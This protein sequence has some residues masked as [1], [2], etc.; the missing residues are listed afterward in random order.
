MKPATTTLTSL[1]AAEPHTMQFLFRW[2]AR[3]TRKQRLLQRQPQA[4]QNDETFNGPNAS[5]A[6]AQ[7]SLE[8]KAS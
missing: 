7:P 8:T 5:L 3:M 1:A 2:L 6:S 4:S